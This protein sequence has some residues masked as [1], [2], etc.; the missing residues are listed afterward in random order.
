MR[1]QV[2][3]HQAVQIVEFAQQ[4]NQAGVRK[5]TQVKSIIGQYDVDVRSA[6]LAV[7]IVK[8]KKHRRRG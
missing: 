4:L 5:E 2:K 6:R 3:F 7:K 8:P 1:D